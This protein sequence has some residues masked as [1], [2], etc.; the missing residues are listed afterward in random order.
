MADTTKKSFNP[1]RF[2]GEV[3]QE[4][5]KVTWTTWRETLITTV[6]V[7]IMVMFAAVFFLAVDFTIS[8][9]IQLLL[10]FFG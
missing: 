8:G 5:R 7:F 10:G 1:F 9:G 3:R 6:M 4:G 2:F